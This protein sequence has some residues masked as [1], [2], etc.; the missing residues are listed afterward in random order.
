MWKMALNVSLLPTRQPLNVPLPI[1]DLGLLLHT[2]LSYSYVSLI[3]SSA[4][5]FSCKG[6]NNFHFPL[7]MNESPIKC[8]R[9]CFQ[10]GYVTSITMAHILVPIVKGD[11][12]GSF[13][14]KYY[15][16]PV[17]G[18]SFDVSNGI[19]FRGDDGGQY[20]LSRRLGM[21]K[22]LFEKRKRISDYALIM[23]MFGIL[24]MIA[25]NELE[26]AGVYRKVIQL[27]HFTNYANQ[28]LRHPFKNLHNQQTQQDINSP[29][30]SA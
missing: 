23:G 7:S 25:E 28:T 9:R 16:K 22:A 11:S 19:D 26:A 29:I 15:I 24:V 20:N 5:W 17:F 8:A 4:Q 30:K 12:H 21:R 13:L 3:Q 10:N 1:I 6:H 27:S 14:S 18:Y 2:I